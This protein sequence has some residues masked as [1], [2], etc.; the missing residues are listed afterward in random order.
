MRI[1]PLLTAL[2]H[3][4]IGIVATSILLAL[5]FATEFLVYDGTMVQTMPIFASENVTTSAFDPDEL[6]IDIT[7]H[8]FGVSAGGMVSLSLLVAGLFAG[9]SYALLGR[10]KH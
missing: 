10:R 7:T 5:L 9:L 4:T 6:N 1:T 3:A 2:S 8:V